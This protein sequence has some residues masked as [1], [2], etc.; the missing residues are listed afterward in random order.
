VCGV[1]SKRY[2]KKERLIKLIR[3]PLVSLGVLF[4]F[5]YRSYDFKAN[6]ITFINI[7]I[8]GYAPKHYPLRDRF[9]K[10][11]ELIPEKYKCVIYKHPGYSIGDA[12]TDI[13]P[14]EFS[15]AINSAKIC[16]TCT[17]K[18]KYRLAKIVEIPACGSALASDIPNQDEESSE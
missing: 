18:H 14:K 11:F 16:L 9:I 2:T 15:D 12:H 5:L 10:V 6:L 7:I 8:K 4:P 1:V 17:S 3:L 13:H